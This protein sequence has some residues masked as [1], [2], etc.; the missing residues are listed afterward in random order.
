M[1]MYSGGVIGIMIFVRRFDL[2]M[3]CGII[4]CCYIYFVYLINLYSMLLYICI[5]SLFN[6]FKFDVVI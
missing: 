1:G 3:D 6:K 5:F 2:C 4:G